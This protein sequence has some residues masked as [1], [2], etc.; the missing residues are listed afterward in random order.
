MAASGSILSFRISGPVRFDPDEVASWLKEK[1]PPA[2][3][4]RIGS[5]RVAA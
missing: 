4:R 3:S 1:Q 5:S 2:A